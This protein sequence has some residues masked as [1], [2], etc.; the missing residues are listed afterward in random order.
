VWSHSLTFVD[1]TFLPIKFRRPV[2]QIDQTCSHERACD[3]F[4][5]LVTTAW[6]GLGV[7]GPNR[8]MVLGVFSWRGGYHVV[9]IAM[10]AFAYIN[11]HLFYQWIQM[12]S[13]LR[14]GH[15]CGCVAY[16][17]DGNAIESGTEPIRNV[18]RSWLA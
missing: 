16:T 7:E 8:L 18:T 12:F 4:A 3:V 6:V 2:Q 17:T 13:V 10:V 11:E 1:H 15:Q 9:A 14:I 5:N